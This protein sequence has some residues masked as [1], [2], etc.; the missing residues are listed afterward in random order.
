[1]RRHWTPFTTDHAS[2]RATRGRTRARAHGLPR[3]LR[4]RLGVLVE[5]RYR[6]HLQPAGMVS[7]LRARGHTVST[8]DPE[9]VTAETDDGDWPDQFDLVVG[10]GRSHALL[11]LLA[12]AESKGAITVN[13]RAAIAGVH[14]K[15][16]MAVRLG[17]AGVPTPKTWI[18]RPADLAER[19][20]AA[21]YPLILKP[22]F[23][24][25]SRG[26]RI[27]TDAD[28][29]AALSWP[30]P[31]ALAQ[32]FVS[33]NGNDLKLYVIGSQ[34]WAVRKPSPL[35]AANGSGTPVPCTPA[36]EQLARRCGVLFGLEL[37]G[38]DCLETD[39]GVVVVE[40]NEFPNYTGV[41]G[42]DDRLAEYVLARVGPGGTP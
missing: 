40:V 15:A 3:T 37:Y 16:E 17:T 1:M 2:G 29:L 14:D 33:T 24:D 31:T 13:R 18:G 38:V 39:A 20:P 41:P 22:S 21:R 8:I 34:V 36:L 7:A 30:E 10:R 27:V 11:C 12:W 9:G 35:R 32:E 23:G 6:S 19:V 25:N 28:E 5:H 42:A 26:L 4:P